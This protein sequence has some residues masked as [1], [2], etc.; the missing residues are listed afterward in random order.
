M[1]AIHGGNATND[2]IDSHKMAAL[3]RGGMRPHASV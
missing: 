2:Q 3:L 1:K